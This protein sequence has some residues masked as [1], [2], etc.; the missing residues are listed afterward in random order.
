MDDLPPK[1]E[2]GA[3]R[4]KLLAL[5]IAGVGMTA[6]GAVLA[7]GVISQGN[8]SVVIGWVGLIFFGFCTLAAFWRLFA[9]PAVVVTLDAEG[10]CDTRISD[11]AIPWSVVRDITTWRSVS[12]RIMILTVDPTFARAL[13]PSRFA[14]VIRSVNRGLG[15]DGLGVNASDLKIGYDKLFEIARA[16]WE[17]SR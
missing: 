16:Y 1:V 14:R 9:A 12:V 2:V 10:I 15:A 11:R 7:F 13:N 17:R 6:L 4:T 3:S 8:V 5:G